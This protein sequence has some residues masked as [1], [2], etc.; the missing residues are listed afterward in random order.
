MFRVFER[1]K[2]KDRLVRIRLGGFQGRFA[3]DFRILL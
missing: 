3:T 2:R 1:N